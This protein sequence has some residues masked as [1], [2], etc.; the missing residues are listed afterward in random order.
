MAKKPWLK[1]S[2]FLRFQFYPWS[3]HGG[4]K[5]YLKASKDMGY[6]LLP[7]RAFFHPHAGRSLVAFW[8]VIA[9]PMERPK[10]CISGSFGSGLKYHKALKIFR[11]SLLPHFTEP[12]CAFGSAPLPPPPPEWVGRLEWCPRL[13]LQQLQKAIFAPLSR[14]KN[15]CLIIVKEIPY[16]V[17]AGPPLAMWLKGVAV[18]P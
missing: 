10:V 15:R 18:W 13:S 1:G 3:S 12:V 11:P 9:S 16:R 2:V 7:I 17:P 6:F 4:K 8:P 14:G 5:P